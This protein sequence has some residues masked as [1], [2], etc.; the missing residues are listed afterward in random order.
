MKNVRI[1]EFE[2]FYGITIPSDFENGE[3]A[4]ELFLELSSKLNT[5]MGE[6][7]EDDFHQ[8]PT[9]SIVY[10]LINRI[11]EQL[12]GAF[13]NICTKN[14]ASSEI[15]SRTSIESAVNVLYFFKD[16]TES[17]VFAWLKKYIEEDKQHIKDWEQSLK[18]LDEQQIHAPK[19]AVRQSL[20]LEKESFVN[21][22]IDEV[23]NVLSIDDS[24]RLPQKI[25]KKFQEIGEETTYH[26]VY[27]RLSAMTHLN[28]ED[29]ISHMI[30]KVSFNEEK[31]IQMGLE[32]CAFSEYMYFYAILFYV[33]TIE[34]FL[35]K[36]A[37]L[38]D[39]KIE[40]LREKILSI[41]NDM[42]KKW[43]W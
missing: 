41:M 1:K 36:Y 22:Y 26:T 29:T 7:K 38:Q 17:K 43:N 18:T 33:N 28:A 24:V 2:D 27:T 32:H 14:H 31:Q 11:Q 42:G 20:N 3:K 34:K 9:V 13:I 12:Q 21:Q 5:A 4:V 6:L 10:Q 8:F 37:Q 25:L 23:K 15:L 16:D 30:A 35:M 39:A 40:S 19:I